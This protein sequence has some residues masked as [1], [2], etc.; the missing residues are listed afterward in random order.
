MITVSCFLSIQVPG[1]YGKSD[2]DELYVR[3]NDA[4]N[5]TFPKV[6]PDLNTF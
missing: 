1:L 2:P 4:R 5:Y 3:E 6:E